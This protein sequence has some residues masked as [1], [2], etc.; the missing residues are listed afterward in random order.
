MILGQFH[1]IF[2]TH[3]PRTPIMDFFT[4][5]LTVAPNSSEA[6]PIHPTPIDADGG[7]N[8]GCVVA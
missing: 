8:G 6:E 4:S 1:N 3:T 7:N 5:P 2:P